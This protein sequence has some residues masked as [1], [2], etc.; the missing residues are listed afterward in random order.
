MHERVIAI[1][2]VHTRVHKQLT[3]DKSEQ[4]NTK[5]SIS[6][7]KWVYENLRNECDK[8]SVLFGDFALGY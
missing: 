2:T 3:V 7:R 1:N 4:S 5:N 8:K 6:L